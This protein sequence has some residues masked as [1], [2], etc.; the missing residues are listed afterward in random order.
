MGDPTVVSQSRSTAQKPG[1][2][3]YTAPEQ[4][5]PS[6]FKQ[7]SGNP[8]KESD[9]HSLAMTAYEVRFPVPLQAQLRTSHRR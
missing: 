6:R 9:V 8:S 7:T 1:L 3:C 5:D 2:T 4:I